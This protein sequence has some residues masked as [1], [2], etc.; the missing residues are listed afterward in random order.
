MK[1]SIFIIIVIVLQF[2]SNAQNL[3]YIRDGRKIEL[4]ERQSDSV[5]AKWAENQKETQI[6]IKKDSIYQNIMTR[7]Q[8]FNDA[9]IFMLQENIPDIKDFI[10]KFVNFKDMYIYGQVDDLLNWLKTE[11]PQRKY[12]TQERQVQL[13]E[14]LIINK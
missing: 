14:I 6:H 1:K 4:N 11:F 7:Q 12:F 2:Q 9:I 8:K 13:L 10:S 5:R 3:F